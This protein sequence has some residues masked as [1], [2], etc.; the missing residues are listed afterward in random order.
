MNYLKIYN[1]IINN[2]EK[3]NRKKLNKSDS[4]YVYYECHHIVPKNLNGTDE[5]NNLVLLTTR[6]HFVCH[7]LLTRIYPNNRGMR[8]AL[9]RF[10]HSI[11]FNLY[12]ISARTYEKIK[13][14]ICEIPV[15]EETKIKMKNAHKYIQKGK[16]HPMFG[17][18]HNIQSKLKMRN[19]KIGKKL[20]IEHKIHLSESHKGKISPNKG[21][22]LSAEWKKKIGD[23]SRGKICSQVKKNKISKANKGKKRTIEQRKQLSERNKNSPKQLCMHCNKLIDKMNYKKWHGINCKMN[24]N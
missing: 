17:K 6:E 13:I 18:H 24:I 21:K 16:D 7:L 1:N 3:D 15:S 19:K 8:L 4:N 5:K 9:R 11:K 2:S 20:S 23:G 14:L 12:K 10:Q 22:K